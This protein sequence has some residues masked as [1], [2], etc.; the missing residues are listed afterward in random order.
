ME[1]WNRGTMEFSVSKADYG[2]ILTSEP[3]HPDKNRY[4]SVK[5]IIPPF[6]YSIIP[7]QMNTAQ[8]IFSDPA[9]KTGSPISE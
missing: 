7:R 6:Q 8:P 5:P 1:K 2:L 4:H 9:R 3:Y